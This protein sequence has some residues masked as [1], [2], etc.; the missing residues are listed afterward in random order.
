MKHINIYDDGKMYAYRIRLFEAIAKENKSILFILHATDFEIE[1]NLLNLKLVN[2]A[3]YKLGRLRIRQGK[4]YLNII[5]SQCVI[6]LN[7]NYPLDLIVGIIFR[8]MFWGGGYTVRACNSVSVQIYLNI[9]SVLGASMILYSNTRL[10]IIS[11]NNYSF[12][13][14]SQFCFVDKYENYKPTETPKKFALFVGRIDSKKGLEELF[15]ISSPDINYVVVGS[16]PE[17]PKLVKLVNKKSLSVSFLPATSNVELLYTLFETCCLVVSPGQ[18]GLLAEDATFFQKK[19]FTISS[20]YSGP[21]PAVAAQDG[22]VEFYDNIIDLYTD[23][24]KFYKNE[25]LHPINVLQQEKWKRDKVHE[26]VKSW[27]DFLKL[28]GNNKNK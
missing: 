13:N 10:N 22:Y 16:G 18:T 19:L 17:L 7:W 3:E 23:M 21:E 6:A 12:R 15:S 14:L 28:N 11:G 5:K 8:S 2:V 26:V 20:E 24:Y 4:D 1:T 27:M 25:R 9:I